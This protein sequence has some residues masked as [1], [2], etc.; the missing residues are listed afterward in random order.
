[1]LMYRRR[2]IRALVAL[3]AVIATSLAVG[4]SGVS[5]GRVDPP[6][7]QDANR[8]INAFGVDLNAL[9]GM[10]DQF[11]TFDCRAISAGEHWI[12]PLWWI[13]DDSEGNIYPAGYT[14]TLPAPVDDFVAKLVAVKFV[15]D[16]GTR[17]QQTLTFNA[18]PITRTDINIE[19][20]EPTGGPP[21]PMASILP[22][23][24]P[25]S[26]G[27]HFIEG[28]VVL[29]ALHCDGLGDSEFNCLPAGETLYLA[30]PVVVTTPA[31]SK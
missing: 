16:P 26:V 10:S 30:H 12:R 5:A 31:H 27:D 1:M 4:V 25:L 8:C 2:G 29:N 9:Y 20:L 7:H 21:L 28:Y 17:Q 22:R 23:V 15:V 19:Q 14:P 11:R 6:G 3:G 24:R 18:G 13:T